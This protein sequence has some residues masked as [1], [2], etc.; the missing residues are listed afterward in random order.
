MNVAWYYTV[1]G[2]RTGP[3]SWTEIK[4]AVDEKTIGTEDYI[5]SSSIGKE[6]RKASTFEG[7]FPSEKEVPV[8]KP[9]KDEQVEVDASKA[10]GYTVNELLSKLPP[11]LASR[12]DARIFRSPFI[13]PQTLKDG[14]LPKPGKI[15]CLKS[16]ATGWSNTKSLLF[17]NFS[18]RRWL[19]L[20]ICVMLTMIS[21]PNPVTWLSSF[22]STD[23]S[24]QPFV[25][26]GLDEVFQTGIFALS[27]E[28]ESTEAGKDSLTNEQKV[29]V[30]ANA[31]R[32]TAIALRNWASGLEATED[33][34]G[35]EQTSSGNK[36][37]TS[38]SRM[39][40]TALLLYA[41]MVTINSW[42]S[43]RGHA[44]MLIR[45]YFPDELALTT[46]VD[47]QKSSSTLFR[48]VLSIKFTFAVLFCIALTKAVLTI[49]Q[50]P[51]SSHILYST[52]TKYGLILFIIPLLDW[53][54]TGF[55]YDF[56][57]PHAVLHGEK[58]L[59]A[60]KTIAKYSGLW[61]TRYLLVLLAGISIFVFSIFFIGILFGTNVQMTVL[62]MVSAP[63]ISALMTLPLH[64]LR[65]FWA[66]DIIFQKRPEMR[67]A[68]PFTRFLHIRR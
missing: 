24:N 54:L 23:K 60:L 52:S 48:G 25:E 6:W 26:L 59:Q 43:A 40:A 5:W 19:L 67:V 13:S 47:A 3:V 10:T 9:E 51:A 56:V 68:I 45:I 63:F 12:L 14:T 21:T 32:T 36:I 55:V 31:A 41:L 28:P 4:K 35:A 15:K 30:V 16:L 39:L 7:L 46:W 17:A 64:V 65:R 20:S 2:T 58:F 44:M 61:I 27:R 38:R 8:D 11:E 50:L 1:K 66:L 18:F 42:F 22:N 37:T 29:E 62:L 33:S 34:D 57:T 49:S 53:I